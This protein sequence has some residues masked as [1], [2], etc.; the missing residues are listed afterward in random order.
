MDAPE[1]KAFVPIYFD[2]GEA[3]QF[4]WSCEYVWIA[5]LGCRLEISHCK[6]ASSRAFWMVVYFTQCHEMLFNAQTRSFSA[7]GGVP[8]RAIYDNMKTAVDKVLRGKG[9][10]VSARFEAMC[11]HYLFEPDVC[12]MASGWEKGIVEKNVLDRRRQ[13]WLEVGHQRWGSL[14]QVNEWNSDR[15]RMAWTVMHPQLPTMTIADV[16]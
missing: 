2:H 10:K 14:E 15:C 6:L 9:R 11:G 13:I 4:D 1:R 12:N 5:G 8:R 3:F 7:F 16:L